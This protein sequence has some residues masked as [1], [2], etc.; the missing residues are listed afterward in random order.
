MGWDQERDSACVQARL[1]LLAGIATLVGGL[2]EVFDAA[3]MRVVFGW[4]TSFVCNPWSAADT[5]AVWGGAPRPWPPHHFHTPFASPV[6]KPYHGY[7]C[8]PKT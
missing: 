7:D 8:S 1:E 4:L 6:L 2:P 3:D 5:S